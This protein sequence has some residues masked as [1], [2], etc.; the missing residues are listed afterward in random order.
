MRFIIFSIFIVFLTFTSCENTKILNDNNLKLV[1]MEMSTL[2]NASLL[3]INGDQILMKTRERDGSRE[4]KVNSSSKTDTKVWR[5]VLQIL[6]KMDLNQFENWPAP[7]DKRLYDGARAV[8]ITLETSEGNI[9]AL[10]FDEGEP[11]VQMKELYEFLVSV[12]NQ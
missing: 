7:T 8:T 4:G 10:P 1:R 5:E 6:S 3:E 12:E 9:V 2:G 11:P